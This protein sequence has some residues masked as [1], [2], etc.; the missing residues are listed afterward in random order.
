MVGRLV[1]VKNA[2]F[3]VVHSLNRLVI[4]V[5]CLKSLVGDFK[6]VSL[7][8]CMYYQWVLNEDFVSHFLLSCVVHYFLQIENFRIVEIIYWFRKIVHFDELV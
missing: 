5:G 3:G 6:M 8:Q 4:T 7:S 1:F 2:W